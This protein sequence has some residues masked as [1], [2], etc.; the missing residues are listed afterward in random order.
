[1]VRLSKRATAGNWEVAAV[2]HTPDKA[3]VTSGGF[4]RCRQLKLCG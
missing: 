3:M 1:M 4:D 2:T